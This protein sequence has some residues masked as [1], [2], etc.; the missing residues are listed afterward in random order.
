MLQS[1]NMDITHH[2]IW[3]AVENSS[4]SSGREGSHEQRQ[5]YVAEVLRDIQVMTESSAS[6]SKNASVE[7]LDPSA[8]PS[9]VPGPAQLEQARLHAEYRCTPCHYMAARASCR[10]GGHCLFCHSQHER[11]SKSRPRKAK[12][13]HCKKVVDELDFVISKG[14]EAF[15][16][17]ISSLLEK[18]SFM[19]LV[20][21]SKLRALEQRDDISPEIS[22][23]AREVHVELRKAEVAKFECDSSDPE[24]S[25][26]G[27][28]AKTT[29]AASSTRLLSL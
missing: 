28:N 5:N 26:N 6:D 23:I 9:D 17:Q 7:L 11:H 13:A 27:E 22:K 20:V 24:K 21:K 16:E 1:G 12:R 25:E 10:K 3:G 4:Q 2:L 29:P 19:T 18:G 14:P 15:K 8:R